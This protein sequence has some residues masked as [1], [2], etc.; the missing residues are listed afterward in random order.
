[1]IYPTLTMLEELGYATIEASEGG[2]KLYA[3]TDEG[4]RALDDNR[5]AVEMI[6]ARMAK[7]QA[8]QG[9]EPAPP[10]LRAME[11]VKLALRLRL[12]RPTSEEQ[13][14]AI[15]AALDAAASQIEQS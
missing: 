10:I 2:R 12:S 13:V 7:V 14:R 8:E 5:A 4:R 15:A 3:L 6:L 9:G 1:M 11:N